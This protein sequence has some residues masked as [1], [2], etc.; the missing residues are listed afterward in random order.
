MLLSK[1]K[2]LLQKA[3]RNYVA[4]SN[5]PY[6]ESGGRNSLFNDKEFDA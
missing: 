4:N 6:F 2:V 5:S 1:P 3:V